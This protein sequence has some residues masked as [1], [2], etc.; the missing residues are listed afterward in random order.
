[1]FTRL[2]SNFLEPHEDPVH[3]PVEEEISPPPLTLSSSSASEKDAVPEFSGALEMRKA[4]SKA[5]SGSTTQR[6]PKP[7]SSAIMT[8]EMG[9]PSKVRKGPSSKQRSKE[10]ANK[11]SH[12][13]QYVRAQERAQPDILKT[14]F[15]H[16]KSLASESFT[17]ITYTP[18]S[19]LTLNPGDLIGSVCRIYS[20]DPESISPISIWHDP[21]TGLNGIVDETFVTKLVNDQ[22]IVVDLCS[23]QGGFHSLGLDSGD[24]SNYCLIQC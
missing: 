13:N 21:Q 3:D 6:K 22:D 16:R 14:I 7:S 9:G 15:M 20:I 17:G 1:M 19:L 23:A 11:A 4:R 10:M 12:P 2:S 24:I 18:M 5:S 8:S